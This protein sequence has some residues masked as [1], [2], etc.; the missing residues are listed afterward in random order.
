[1]DALAESRTIAEICEA[2]YGKAE[3]Y[4]LLLIIEKTG[5]YA[6]YLYEHDM[7]EIV[8]ADEGARLACA[9]SEC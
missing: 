8:N 9:V 4:N 7:I 6:E 3:G 5:A 2:V 1:M